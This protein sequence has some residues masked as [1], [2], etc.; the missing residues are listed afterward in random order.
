MVWIVIALLVFVAAAAAAAVVVRRQRR[1]VVE[2]NQVVPGRPTNAP[3]SWAGSHDPE[4]R[5]HRRLRDAMTALRTVAAIDDATTIG[6]RASIEESA[7]AVDNQL[8]SIAALAREYREQRL[9][10]AHRA[11]ECVEAAVAQYATAATRHATTA[12]EADLADVRAQLAVVAEIRGELS[13]G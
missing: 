12:L 2:R 1:D 13:A 11:V 6:L 5:L 7:V 9:P 10:Q 3:L 4:A 8:V